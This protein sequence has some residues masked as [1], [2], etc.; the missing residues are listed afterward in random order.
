MSS[1]NDW[2]DVLATI[3]L[4]DGQ[5]PPLII[6]AN[7]ESCLT[8]SAAPEGRDIWNGDADERLSIVLDSRLLTRRL[9][10]CSIIR[11]QQRLHGRIP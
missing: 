9:D 7:S 11:Q 4:G 2:R 1:D 3:N 6:S 8:K 10:R 5:V